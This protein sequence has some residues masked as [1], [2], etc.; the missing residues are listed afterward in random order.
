[1]LLSQLVMKVVIVSVCRMSSWMDRGGMHVIKRMLTV[2]TLF[3]KLDIW[4][5]EVA[6]RSF[7][8]RGP[9]R[10][11]VL[12]P[13]DCKKMLQVRR[14][15]RDVREVNAQELGL[16][17]DAL[18]C[19]ADV[20]HSDLFDALC[21]VVP[22]LQQLHR[23][24]QLGWVNDWEGWAEVKDRLRACDDGA[25]KRCAIEEIVLVF[26]NSCQKHVVFENFPSDETRR[27]Y[28]EMGGFTFGSG[29]GHGC[30]SFVDSLLQFLLQYKFLNGPSAGVSMAMWR[31]EVCE[32]VRKHLCGHDNVRLRPRQRN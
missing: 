9:L 32:L 27:K 29:S 28:L 24:F 20:V 19:E 1:M 2:K 30:N 25:V 22:D 11:S 6:K 5:S 7:G 3:V 15:V 8:V 12:F 17:L 10:V 31:H 4:M 21:V 18:R 14:G 23:L 26:V 13:N 16:M